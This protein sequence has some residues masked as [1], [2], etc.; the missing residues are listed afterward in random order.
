MKKVELLAPAGNYESFLGAVS[1]GADAIYLG[2]DKFGARAFAENFT[3]EQLCG[4]IK[5]AH[6]LGRKVY[7]TLNTLIKEKEFEELYSYIAPFYEAGLDGIIVQDLGVFSYV[8][9]TFPHLPL[10]VSTQMTVTGVR[11][12]KMLKEEGAER[13]VPA[14]EL[15]L[16][17]IK[18]M[19]EETGLELE[20]FI[21]GAM[22]YC[23]SGQCLFSSL[24]GG[25]SGNRGKC[26]QPCRLP[27]EITE[28]G[29]SLSG[30][31]SHPLS[32]KDMCT[33]EHIPDLIEAGIDSFKIEGRMKKAEYAAGVTAVYRKYID[34]YYQKGREGYR[35]LPEDMRLLQSLY[36]RSEIQDGYYYRHNG[37]EM[38]THGT[39][40]YSGSD[41]NIL[42]EIRKKYLEKTM[43]LPVEMEAH[44]EKDKEAV[45][46]LTSGKHRVTVAGQIVQKAQKQ[47]V[48]EKNIAEGLS[49]LGDTCFELSGLS[50]AAQEDIFYPLK[51]IKDLRREGIAQLCREVEREYFPNLS[52]RQG[53]GEVR[54]DIGKKQTDCKKRQCLRVGVLREEQL[55]AVLKYGKEISRLYI[56]SD[57]YRLCKENPGLI[58]RL[59]DWKKGGEERQVYPVLPY[60]LRERDNSFLEEIFPSFEQMDGCMVR[61]LEGYYFLK[62]KGYAKPICADAGVYQW[63]L[64]CNTFWSDKLQGFCIPYELS[65]KEQDR[66]L[67]SGDWEQVVY[68]YLPM[69]ITANCVAK[70]SGNCL[71]LNKNRAGK[72]FDYHLKDRYRAEF[73][74]YVNCSHC[75]NVIYNS[76]PL[77]LH[78]KL[79]EKKSKQS[80]RLDFTVESREETE[81]IMEYFAALCNGEIRKRPYDS[82][83]T[84][85]EKKGAL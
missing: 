52:L 12:A 39:P 23:Y 58:K 11:G 37:K 84:G 22:C 61:N 13:I 46:T 62:E 75:Y 28:K 81:K 9:R 45:L 34:L 25:R 79:A 53:A 10:H 31:Y 44:F 38:I 15:S 17:E 55:E 43:K 68:G 47:P 42:Q 64:E 18:K 27:Y 74:V 72:T 2:G 32:L 40:G 59:Q 70:T 20:T 14:R 82:F 19:K 73:P 54:S 51:A 50:I 30:E 71:L 67:Q 16:K 66:L 5:Y 3:Q 65:G 78:D 69:M 77:S 33:I 6:L 48:T 29:K 49:A 36:I 41:E 76:V 1:A 83:T 7:L 35:V 60:I 57:L 4:A 85:H 80:F 63:N 8:R 24:L 21:H 56:D 26:A